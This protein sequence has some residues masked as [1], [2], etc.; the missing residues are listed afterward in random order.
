MSGDAAKTVYIRNCRVK[1][2]AIGP[3][4]ELH[5]SNYMYTNAPFLYSQNPFKSNEMIGM[6]TRTAIATR[7]LFVLM[8]L[9]RKFEYD[10]VVLLTEILLRNDEAFRSG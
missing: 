6:S 3:D 4:L 9:V 7:F 8:F 2:C 10:C 5:N 1:T